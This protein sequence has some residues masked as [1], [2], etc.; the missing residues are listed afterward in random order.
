MRIEL[1]LAGRRARRVITE[2]R[3]ANLEKLN[4]N[5]NSDAQHR[6]AS[7]FGHQ[8]AGSAIDRP[9]STAKLLSAGSDFRGAL[10]GM[11]RQRRRPRSFR[12]APSLGRR[13]RTSSGAADGAITAALD[14]FSKMNDKWIERAT[15]LGEEAIE[16]ALSQAGLERHRYRSHL[17]HH[18]YW[19]RIAQH[20]R[21]AGQPHV[22][23][24]RISSERRS[25]GSVAS[26]E[27]PASREPPIIC[28]AFPSHTAVLVSVELCS[29]TLQL[30]DQSIAN[31]IASGLFADGAA[32][33][34]VNGGAEK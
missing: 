27:L 34:I 17:L 26:A 16:S 2:A 6:N 31:V 30:K 12:A 23:A 21:Q 33:V 32:A 14:S 24:G 19:H 20:R 28:V 9:R 1:S 25:S 29:L 13:S 8:S 18:R 22:D 3:I 15:D 11:E 7:A 5:P 4:G 10:E